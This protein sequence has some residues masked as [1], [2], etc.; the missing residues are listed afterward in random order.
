MWLTSAIRWTKALFEHLYLATYDTEM[1]IIILIIKTSIHISIILIIKT[2][3]HISIIIIIST[4]ISIIII[5]ILS[6]IIKSII[7]ISVI[8]IIIII[9]IIIIKTSILISIVIII[10]S[11]ILISI[12]IIIIIIK[13]IIIIIIIMCLE[14][15]HNAKSVHSG[16]YSH[17]TGFSD[18]PRAYQHF[19][20]SVFLYHQHIADKLKYMHAQNTDHSQRYMRD[21]AGNHKYTSINRDVNSLSYDQ[22]LLHLS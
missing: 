21:I 22:T 12:I 20:A 5:I 6:S 15:E 14:W 18:Y 3:I 13:T 10:K 8:I 9:S 2:R 1:G 19:G 17:Q 7:L 4:S 16:K 11:I